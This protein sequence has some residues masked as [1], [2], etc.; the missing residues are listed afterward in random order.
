MKSTIYTLY[1]LAITVIL[2]SCGSLSISQMR[3]SRGL[4][5]DLFSSKEK[6]PEGQKA[7]I[8]TKKT[9]E[10][11]ETG[12]AEN[13]AEVKETNSVNNESYGITENIV[14]KETK[15]TSEKKRI[16]KFS[17]VRK[18][19]K[20]IKEIIKDEQSFPIHVKN[21]NVTATKETNDGPLLLLVILALFPILCLIAVYLHDDGITTNFWIDLV[22]HLTVF[23]AVIYALL[24]VLDIID[25]S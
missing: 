6:K 3:Y 9:P 24:V 15:N 23:G 21:S 11:K 1:F 2:S 20:Q 16:N 8:A 12:I 18:V 5:V 14:P 25:L 10:K 13:K 7:K 19:S 17:I 4:N 22:L